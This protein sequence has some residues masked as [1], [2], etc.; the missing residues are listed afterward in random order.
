MNVHQ[1][2]LVQDVSA[3]GGKVKSQKSK[4]KSTKSPSQRMKLAHFLAWAETFVM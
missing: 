2:L 1:F 3:P 4:V